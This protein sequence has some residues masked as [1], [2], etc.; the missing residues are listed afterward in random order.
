VQAVLL[1]AAPPTSSEIF[2]LV[3][4]VICL[5]SGHC[6][7]EGGREQMVVYFANA[8]YRCPIGFN[9]S[10]FAIFLM[11]T[12]PRDRLDKMIERWAA[13]NHEQL[14]GG[15]QKGGWLG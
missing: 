13:E 3:D 11:Q 14:P 12:E 6:L 4:H 15:M 8:G 1:S 2:A 5:C 7:Y 9:P 10:D